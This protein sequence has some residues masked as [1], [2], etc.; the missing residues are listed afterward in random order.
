M[1]AVNGMSLQRFMVLN[2]LCSVRAALL[3][4]GPGDL[5]KDVALQHGF[6][7]LG[8]FAKTYFN[9]FGE[10]PSQ[11]IERVRG[12]RQVSLLHKPLSARLADAAR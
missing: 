5:I 2:R 4:A 12:K 8:R 9:C 3:R 7:H 6:W 1:V 11:T 10:A